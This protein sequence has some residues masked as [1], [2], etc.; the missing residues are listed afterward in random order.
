MR[1]IRGAT[2]VPQDDGEF[3]IG[4]IAQEIQEVFLTL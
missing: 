2:L 3:G 4:M 1:K